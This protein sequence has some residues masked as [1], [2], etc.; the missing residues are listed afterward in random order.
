MESGSGL[1]GRLS[2]LAKRLDVAF[3]PPNDLHMVSNSELDKRCCQ[4]QQYNIGRHEQASQNGS[5]RWITA[6]NQL[7]RHVK[8]ELSESTQQKRMSEAK[9]L[10]VF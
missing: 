9:V 8:V 2:D 4:L 5:V 1:Y 3:P 7:E 10:I 6:F